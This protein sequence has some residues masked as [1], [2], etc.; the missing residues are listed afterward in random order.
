M[1]LK[2]GKDCATTLE[3][4]GGRTSRALCQTPFVGQVSLGRL[5]C[6]ESLAWKLKRG[7]I[8]AN[9]LPCARGNKYISKS[10][11][12]FFFDVYVFVLNRELGNRALVIVL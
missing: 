9:T 2:Q 7:A 10:R 1:S 3:G 6:V 11:R 12:F 5:P 8:R 4:D